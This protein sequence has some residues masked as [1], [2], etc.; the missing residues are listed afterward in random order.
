M[1]ND[2]LILYPEINVPPLPK[3]LLELGMYVGM[4]RQSKFQVRVWRFHDEPE[5]SGLVESLKEAP[6]RFVLY[7]IEPHQFP[8]LKQTAPTLKEE[9]LDI[10]FCCGGLMPTLNPDRVISVSGVDSLVIG[11][12]EAALVEFLSSFLRGKDYRKIRNFWFKTPLMEFHKNPLRPLI[13]DLDVIPF[14]DRSFYST[15]Q[16]Y[17]CTGGALPLLVSRGCEYNCLFCAQPQIRSIYRGKGNFRRV[18]SVNHVI[19][20]IQ[21]QRVR[22]SFSSVL[23]TDEIF[24]TSRKW[25]GKFAERYQSQ[26]NLPF[27][28]TC[29]MEQL[30]SKTLELLVIAGCNSITI[31]IETGD[32]A[33]RKRISDRNLGKE[34]IAS[35]IKSIKEMGIKVHTTNM[36]G[37]PLETEELANQSFVLNQELDPDRVSVSVF[38]PL[39]STP[40]YKYS[41]EKGYISNRSPLSLGQGE[42]V[43]NLPFLTGELIRKYYFKLK[44][45]NCGQQISRSGRTRGFFDILHNLKQPYDDQESPP[46]VLCDTF[47]LNGKAHPCLVQL[48]NTKIT[49]DVYIKNRSYFNFHI[50]IEPGMRDFDSTAFFRFTVVII[51]NKKEQTLFE[52][53]IRPADDP[54]YLKWFDYELPV[55]DIEEGE[56]KMRFEYRTSLNTA[57]PIRG[58]WGRPFLTEKITSVE[59]EETG[60]TEEDIAKLQK[61]LLQNTLLLQRVE[62]DR[63]KLKAEKEE[64]KEEKEKHLVLIGDLE[65]RVI[66]LEEHIKEDSRELKELEKIREAYYKTLSG[67]I[68]KLFK[69]DK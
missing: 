25:L 11:E 47:T 31:G 56:A 29:V 27:H 51:Q 65:N 16:M 6:P 41:Q 68:R 8:F 1:A 44:I 18:R 52:K 46:K 28:V 17:G 45:L 61:D 20:E 35:M 55:L 59:M 12:G 48:P 64:M 9:F 62:K 7:Y 60:F 38:F 32:V 19:S 30:D 57:Y 22:N 33:F 34:K 69:K 15:E 67:R 3:T 42:S 26:V 66:Q 21:E 54:N 10:H 23:F 53:Y 36:I 14:P 58:L 43:L 40:L 2:I 49:L 63:D 50:G 37:L 4:L 5:I 39:P 13:E 24:P